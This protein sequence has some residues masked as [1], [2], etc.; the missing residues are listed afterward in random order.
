MRASG[1]AAQTLTPPLWP[2]GSGGNERFAG[3]DTLTVSRWLLVL[4]GAAVQILACTC[5]HVCHHRL[6]SSGLWGM[7]RGWNG[8]RRKRQHTRLLLGCGER[9][10]RL[11]HRRKREGEAKA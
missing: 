11:N 10:Q 4:A 3:V 9:R 8:R 2:G 1:T 7:C 5:C 6:A